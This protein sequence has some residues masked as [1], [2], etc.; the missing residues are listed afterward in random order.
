M[1]VVL[2]EKTQIVDAPVDRDVEYYETFASCNCSAVSD[3]STQVSITW[4]HI[5]RHGDES[6]VHNV[7]DRIVIADNGTLMLFVPE[8]ATEVWLELSGTY[9]CSAS[10]GYSTATAAALIVPSGVVITPAPCK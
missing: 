5:D 3:D 4:Y 8:N 10:N 6:V 9:R 1:I 2:A 7:T